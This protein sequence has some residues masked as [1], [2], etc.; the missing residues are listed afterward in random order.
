MARPLKEDLALKKYG[1]LLVLCRDGTR[2]YRIWNAMRQR[3]HNPNQPHYERYGARGIAVCDEWRQSFGAFLA[4]MGEPPT[5]GHSLDRIDNDLGYS[6]SNCR[7]ATAK[8]QRAN[9][10]K[11]IAQAAPSRGGS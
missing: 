11:H 6:P 7:W 3:C 5:D 4:D 2:V 10:R 1:R 9:R 8:E